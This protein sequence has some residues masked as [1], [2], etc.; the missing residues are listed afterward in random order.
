MFSKQQERD[1]KLGFR[2]AFRFQQIILI[3]LRLDEGVP[4]ELSLVSPARLPVKTNS[5]SASVRSSL[6]IT[7]E[8]PTLTT[9]QTEQNR[10]WY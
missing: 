7:I 10:P 6:P 8:R 4:L 5:T 3:N 9:P 1:N 2:V